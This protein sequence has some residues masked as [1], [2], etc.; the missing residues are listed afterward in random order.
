[1]PDTDN[2]QP[3]EIKPD[4]ALCPNCL[5]PNDPQAHFCTNC[6]TPMS[7]HACIDPIASIWARGDIWRKASLHPRRP[8]HVFGMWLL[9]AP[10]VL[11]TLAMSL[12]VLSQ[13]LWDFSN[14]SLLA[15]YFAGILIVAGQAC[16]YSA[17][18]WKTTRNYLRYIKSPA[19]N[20]PDLQ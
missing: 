17:I 10:T 1:M 13:G 15:G 16:L 18:L 20:Q 3:D 12:E 8:M 4:Q 6:A 9:F 14:T 19:A 5:T 11:S 7:S 2:N